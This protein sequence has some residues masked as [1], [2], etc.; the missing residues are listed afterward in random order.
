MDWREAEREYDGFEVERTTIPAMFE[1]AAAEHEHRPAQRYKGGVYERSL[2]ETVMPAAP[3]GEYRTISYDEMRDVVRHLAAGFRDL[4]VKDGRRVAIHAST[5]MEWAQSD[6]AA[7]AAGGVVT[8]VY[9][10]SS[11]RQVEYLLSDPDATGV[12]VEHDEHLRRVLAVED[13]LDLEFV[14]QIDRPGSGVAEHHDADGADD[15]FDAAAVHRERDDVLTLAEVHDR[16]AELFHPD[17]YESWL[18]ERDADDLCTLIYTSGTTGQPKGV[19]L[20]HWNFGSNVNQ[21]LRR[22]GD[23]PDKEGPVLDETTDRISYLPLAHVYERNAGHFSIFAVGACV[24][25][26]ESP[27]TLREDFSLINPD[28]TTSVP[29]VYEKLYD[30]IREQAST[31][32]R[33]RR[34]FEWAVEVGQEYHRT[35]SPGLVLRGKRAIADQLVFS[36]VRAA[37]GGEMELMLS[38]GG[39]LSPELAALYQGMGIKILEGYGLTETSPTVTSNPTEAPKIGTIGPPLVGIDVWV[40]E[41]A[42]PDGQFPEDDGPT[43]ELFVRGPNVT[44]GY[45]N[46]PGET[47]N[48]FV[49]ELPGGA[50]AGPNH[51][52]TE[53]GKWF[54]TGDIVHQRPDGY[55]E[56][57]ERAKQLLVLSTGKN[58]APA[59]IEDAFAASAVVEQCMVV[60]DGR[61]FVGA[62]LVPNHDSLRSWADEEEIDLPEDPEALAAHEA[63]R[64]RIQAEVDRINE[65]FESHETIKRFA[66]GPEEFT[67]EN[68]L[69]TP[70]MKKKRRD[71]LS[72]YEQAVESLY[73]D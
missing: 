61:K 73:E 3:A 70:T 10:S 18:D 23:R 36:K 72:R 67:E 58:V 43:G 32:D 16:G 62:L 17:D 34:I 37:L 14:V 55:F 48:A 54:R 47:E 45:W 30:A 35:D 9:P 15:E 39:S 59:P 1:R 69:L 33:S 4:G 68:G 6:F 22:F 2:T 24:A 65:G 26:A 71:I 56:F 8:T 44:D 51:E 5:R 46:K 60:G 57:R 53:S 13:E 52:W 21:A 66:I 29:R 25:Y 38:G 41:S 40:D 7:L 11:E 31:S 64:E 27:E 63:V 50:T 28:S 49:E 20:T 42:V 19:R 12:V